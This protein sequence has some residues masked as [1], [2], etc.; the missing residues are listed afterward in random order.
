MHIETL[1]K[2]FQAKLYFWMTIHLSIMTVLYQ[3]SSV[4]A[5]DCVLDSCGLLLQDRIKAL[6]EKFAAAHPPTKVEVCETGF[7][8]LPGTHSCY[9]VVKEKLSWD[10]SRTRCA[11]LTSTSHLVEINNADENNA[12]IDHLN[13][14]MNAW[15]ASGTDVWNCV[16]GNRESKFYTA[17]Q[18]IDPTVCSS[19]RDFVWKLRDSET[20]EMNYI[21]WNSGEPNCAGT[22]GEHCL[23]YDA[24]DSASVT[25]IW[26]DINCS[27]TWCPICEHSPTIMTID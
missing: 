17:G 8:L 23:A 13:A 16:S 2:M 3:V 10:D 6:E 18:R 11:S 12:V 5:E 1:K 15:G 27:E 24:Y 7:I 4:S 26:N 22:G 14:I 21:K 25:H 19:D 20:K 9:Q